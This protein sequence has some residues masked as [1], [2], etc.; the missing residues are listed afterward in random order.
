MNDMLDKIKQ[1]E[2]KSIELVLKLL[3]PNTANYYDNF[4]ELSKQIQA[5]E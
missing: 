4:K 1:I 3:D 2:E 5:L